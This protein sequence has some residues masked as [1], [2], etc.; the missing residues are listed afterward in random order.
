M[1]LLY[2]PELEFGKKMPDFDLLGTDKQQWT[3]AKC[4]GQNGLVVLFIC[5]HCP[6][7]QSIQDRLVEDALS[8]QNIGVNTVAIMSN[9][10]T[11]YPE[12]SFANM[13]KIAQQHNYPFAYLLDDTQ[14]VAKDY[15]AVCTPDVFGLNHKAEL[16]YRG[17][18]DAAGSTTT[19]EKLPRDL[20]NAMQEL[21]TKGK[22]ITQQIPSMGCSIKWI[23]N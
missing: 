10:V 23:N 20:V 9:D 5:N 16:H 17:R 12:D 6:Y 19:Q 18:L 7:V 15:G 22:I 1:T 21:V 2:T 13:Q 14:K 3:L 8:L 11:S 4:M